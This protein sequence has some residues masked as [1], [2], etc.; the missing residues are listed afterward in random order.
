MSNWQPARHTGKKTTTS[1]DNVR[2]R[3]ARVTKN[4]AMFLFGIYCTIAEFTVKISEK[5]PVFLEF[6][7]TVYEYGMC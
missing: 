6:L 5:R 7:Y 1:V 3:S 4:D 2:D